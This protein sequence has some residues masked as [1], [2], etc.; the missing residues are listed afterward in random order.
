MLFVL[1]CYLYCSPPQFFFTNQMF[2]PCFFFGDFSPCF[3]LRSFH[4]SNVFFMFLIA[5]EAESP[6][7]PYATSKSFVV[8]AGG[9]MLIFST[10][11]EAC[12][13]VY[14]WIYF[15]FKIACFSLFY[16]IQNEFLFSAVP[17]FQTQTIYTLY[18]RWSIVRVR[19]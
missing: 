18:G 5:H 17:F 14:V 3:L 15:I 12:G 7:I 16:I 1:S 4:D 19:N 6:K 13:T 8:L 11:T 2:S 10:I 9:D